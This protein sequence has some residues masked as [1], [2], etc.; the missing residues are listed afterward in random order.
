LTAQKTKKGGANQYGKIEQ[1]KEHERRQFQT[2]FHKVQGYDTNR[3]SVFPSR[4]YHSQ[5]QRERKT[6]TES[7]TQLK[8]NIY[9]GTY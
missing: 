4:C 1:H 6:W 8:L 5:Q 2:Y 3:A 7:T 9:I